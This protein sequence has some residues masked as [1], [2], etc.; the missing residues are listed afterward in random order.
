MKT[1]NQPISPESINFPSR[2]Y[3]EILSEL[4]VHHS[5]FYH[6]WNLGKPSF[7]SRIPTAQVGFDR[8]GNCINFLINPNFWDS[9]SQPEKLFVIAHECMHVA[10]EHGI[11]GIADWGPRANK[12]M[13]VVVNHTLVNKFGFK[14]DEIDPSNKYCWIDT[15]FGEYADQIEENQSFEYYYKMHKKLFPDDDNGGS[16]GKSGSGGSGG[17]L[18]DDHSGMSASEL[19]GILKEVK[20]VM[21]DAEK[22]SLQEIFESISKTAGKGAG[23]MEW[24]VHK[25]KVIKKAKW[26]TIIKKWTKKYL[27]TEEK[28]VDQ[29]VMT[30][31]RMSMLSQELFIP[32]EMEMEEDSDEKDRIQVWFFQ[33]TS[34]SCSGFRDRFFKAAE[35]LPKE[36]FDIKMHC[37]DTEVYE[38]TLKSRKLYGFGGTS[39]SVIE[40]Y[41]INYINKHKEPYP[42]AVFVITDGFSNSFS[43]KKPQNWFWF[44]T[45]D[46][47]TQYIPKESKIFKLSDY[48]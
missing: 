43:C 40:Q 27:R 42:E 38:T 3:M 21:G 9:L 37:F 31:R 6:L 5:L 25:T 36:R 34:G 17:E 29:W 46:S 8:E 28:D 11:R 16:D 15:C 24:F 4:Q 30:N 14:K 33:D 47:T 41:I 35:S 7:C 48:E 22:E 20:E 45:P 32:S 12:M 1:E 23:G 2:L 19:E 44:L 39:F 13:D 10:L 18:V 26:E